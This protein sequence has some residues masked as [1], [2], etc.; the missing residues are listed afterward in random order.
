MP[1]CT[2]WTWPRS[3]PRSAPFSAPEEVDLR[4]DGFLAEVGPI[5]SLVNSSVA[6]PWT[7]TED[8][9]RMEGAARTPNDA[10]NIAI[11]AENER[12]G[13]SLVTALSHGGHYQSPWPAMPQSFATL[14][15][16]LGRILADQG[17]KAGL[18]PSC[19]WPKVK[20]DRLRHG[21]HRCAARSD[22][23]NVGPTSGNQDRPDRPADHGK[24]RDAVEPDVDVLGQPAVDAGRRRF[25]RGRLWR[26]PSC[27]AREPGAAVGDGLVVRLCDTRGRPLEH[28]QRVVHRHADRHRHR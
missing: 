26:H 22:R 5:L 15:E 4:L 27:L 1:C 17:R 20:I 24:R 16:L 2:K 25:V 7:C 10:A 23:A 28:P 3:A 13:A 8:S 11:D 18:W 6:E 21:I 19:G 9:P 12:F 14:S